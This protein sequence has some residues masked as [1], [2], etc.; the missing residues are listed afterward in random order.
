MQS[1]IINAV[2]NTKH[3]DIPSIPKDKFKL[4]SE[5]SGIWHVNWKPDSDLSKKYQRSI[6]D[7][8]TTIDIISAKVLMS[9]SSFLGI[10]HIIAI[11]A[12][13]YSINSTNIEKFCIVFR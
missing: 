6:V 11:P 10:I 4:Y 3:K 1:G 5:I 13:R 12:A 2:N 8:N 7:I 9:F